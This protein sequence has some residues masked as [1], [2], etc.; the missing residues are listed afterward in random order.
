MH[1]SL[2]SFF[3]LIVFEDATLSFP[4]A[5]TIFGREGGVDSFDQAVYIHRVSE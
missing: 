2:Q 4:Q 3:E 1:Q 5:I